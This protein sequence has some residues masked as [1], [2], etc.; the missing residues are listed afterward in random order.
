MRAILIAAI[1]ARCT[2]SDAAMAGIN[3]SAKII[4]PD[5]RARTPTQHEYW[6]ARHPEHRAR[7]TPDYTP[8]GNQ[9]DDTEYRKTTAPI[10]EYPSK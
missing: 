3:A 2:F 1:F 7:M 6:I 9:T 10:S 4:G 5:G 8:Q